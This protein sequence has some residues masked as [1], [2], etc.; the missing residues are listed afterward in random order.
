MR[1]EIA[2]IAKKIEEI[3]G[4]ENLST[5][6]TERFCYSRDFSFI[7]V[8][9]E[10]MPDVIVWPTS[11]EQV[12]QIVKLANQFKIP[13]VPRGAGTGEHGGA[14]PIKGGI[15]LD[16]TKM[17]KILEIDEEN[18][19]CLVEPGIVGDNLSR[20]LAK[21]GF[22]LPPMTASSEAC[23]VGGNAANNSAGYRTVKYGSYRNWVLGLEV[24]L[25]NGNVIWTGA[26]TRKSSS[27]YDLTRL[28]VGS[29]GTLGI[30]TKIRLRIHPLPEC[31]KVFLAF[32]NNVNDASKT[33]VKIMASKIFPSSAEIMDKTSIEAVTRY[34]IKLPKIGG[35]VIVELDGNEK[36]VMERIEQVRNIALQYGAIDTR[37]GVSAK[38]DEELWKARKSVTPAFALIRPNVIDED[39]A[40]PVTKLP[41]L[42]QRIEQLSKEL[43]IDIATYGH[44]GDGD[45]HPDIL[46]DQRDS[47]EVKRAIIAV[48]KLREITIDL[49]G[50]ITGEHG[51]GLRRAPALKMEHSE[52]E[53]NVMR[54]IK[55]VIDPNNIMN[56]GK[57]FSYDSEVS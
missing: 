55:R 28:F 19:T 29:E 3:V 36:D 17:N 18:M 40:V 11:V 5:E 56:P 24:V 14:M 16:F 46:F 27:G 15:L 7:D 53:I 42:F 26:K 43:N 35:M 13:V 45:L 32:Y 34:G 2:N 22:F 54:L 44:A 10:I 20:V 1:V 48:D 12:T 33:I 23:T 41:E 21:H 9:A 57:I 47:D 37:V 50:T 51:I 52:E 31:R 30:F 25:P 39:I 38:E 49:G 4:R 8:E 6:F